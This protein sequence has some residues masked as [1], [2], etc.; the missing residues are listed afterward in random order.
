MPFSIWPEKTGRFMTEYGF[1]SYPEMATIETFTTP[2]ERHLGSSSL[3]NHQKHSRGVE[4]IR[5][6]MQEDFRYTQTGDLDEFAYVSQLV[7]AEGIVQAI[8]AHRIQHDKCRGTLYWQLNDCWPVASWS[9][10]DATGRWK[11]LHYRLKE[12][13]ANV[14][15]AV[16]HHADNTLDVYLV[17]D[18]LK[19]MKG[20]VKVS[21]Y[22]VSGSKF[23][24]SSFKS[25]VGADKAVKVCVLHPGDFKGIAPNRMALKIQFVTEGKVIAERICYLVKPGQLV[26]GKSDIKQDFE[27]FGDYFELTLTAP[28][29]HY[30]VQLTETVGKEVRWSDN[31]FD[32]LPNEP[33]TVR[34]Y[35]DDASGEKPK[36]RVRSF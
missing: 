5:K 6:A 32:L 18:G 1:Q 29:L 34:C 16:Q 30:G 33:K 27:F 11:A 35:Y 4:I 20:E 17:N 21:A 12:A 3:N 15:V 7:Q 31:Y 28:T 23:Q 14:S 24:V 10:I 9:S 36:V 22:E 19:A 2:A 8:D 26:L 13:Y 25:A